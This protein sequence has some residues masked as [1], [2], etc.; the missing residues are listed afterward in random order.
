ML[1]GKWLGRSRGVL[2][3]LRALRELGEPAAILQLLDLLFD[4]DEAIAQETAITVRELLKAV[5]MGF[6]PMLDERLRRGGSYRP[7]Q[8]RWNLLDVEALRIISG[9]PDAILLLEL[10]SSH[11][12]GHVRETALGLLDQKVKSGEEIPFILLRLDDWVEV[13]S[14]WAEDAILERLVESNRPAFLRCLP[15]VMR[16]SARSRA[17]A[18]AVLGRVVAFFQEDISAL[19]I[20]AMEI[21]DGGAR[22]YGLSL[23]WRIAMRKGEEA[24]RALIETATKSKNPA[25]RLVAALWLTKTGVTPALTRSYLADLLRDRV[26]NVRYVALSWCVV[27]EPQSFREELR[28]ALLDSNASLRSLAQFYLPRLEPMDVRGFYRDMVAAGDSAFLTPALGGLGET[29][30]AEDA[31][32]VFPLLEGGKIS[33][34]KAALAALARLA[35]GSHLELFVRALQDRSPGVSKQARIVLESR[36][37]EIGDERLEAIIKSDTYPHV[38]RQTLVLINR[39][40]KWKKLPLLIQVGGNPDDSLQPLASVFL[41]VCLLTY[42]RTHFLQPT[43]SEVARLRAAFETNEERLE[44]RIRQELKGLVEIIV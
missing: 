34:R 32:L 40:P 5:P 43:Q 4:S 21:E 16:L 27:H 41:Q 18:S 9:R 20:A 26:I 38:R 10:A 7:A 3:L 28:A 15:L 1:S 44:Y 33:V 13:V 2:P 17:R 31:T 12:N 19:A 25:V 37:G 6:Y 29:G 11:G 22:H 14:T 36:V 23:A 42:N 35:P 39:L 24:Q 8:E 30:K